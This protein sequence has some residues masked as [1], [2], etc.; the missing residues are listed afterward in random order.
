M[1]RL[2]PFSDKIYGPH[3]RGRRRF[4][5][6][7]VRDIISEGFKA[8]KRKM[9]FGLASLLTASLL[10]GQSLVDVSKQ[11]KE[12]RERLK[13]KHARVVTNADLQAMARKPSV[14]TGEA[15]TA[16]PPAP[17]Q[18]GAAGQTAETAVEPSQGAAPGESGTPSPYAEAVSP[19]TSVVKNPEFALGAPD[20]RFAEISVTGTLDLDFEARN[21]P[22]D[23]IA[24]YS[25]RPDFNVPEAEKGNQLEVPEAAMWWG[26]FR[27]AVLGLTGS[28][29]WLEIGLGSG[30]Y[31]DR[32]DLRTLSS[33]T[34]IRIMFKTYGNP[35][36][37]GTNPLRLTEG[38]LTFGI[39][40]VEALH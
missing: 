16:G 14:V 21:G 37:I 11:E 23:D 12:R 1:R 8:M 9:I 39:D 38:E 33:I 35:Y 32:F 22:G 17:G 3:E 34:K 10:I 26:D 20:G 27:Y 19:D 6:R 15:E 36:N 28:G 29:E 31:P 30:N 18:E 4:A 13:G 7:D 5:F 24:I 2:A 40:S 25:R